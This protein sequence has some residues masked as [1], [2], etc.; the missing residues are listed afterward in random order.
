MQTIVITGGSSG[1][2]LATAEFFLKHGWS[3]MLVGRDPEK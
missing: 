3:T 1:I 2:G